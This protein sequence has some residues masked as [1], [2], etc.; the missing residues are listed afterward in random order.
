MATIAFLHKD[1][2]YCIPSQGWP[3][4]HSFT[5]MATITFLHKDGHY[6][7]P[8]QGWPLLHSFS[9]MATI[10]F[11]HKDGHYCIPSQGWP[12]L[13]SFTRM[14]TIAFLHKDGHYCIPSQ[15]WPLL[16]SFSRMATIE[17]VHCN[18]GLVVFAVKLIYLEKKVEVLLLPPFICLSYS[19]LQHW[20]ISAKGQSAL[21]MPKLITRL[22]LLS[23]PV[24]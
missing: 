12:L 14:A 6:C 23:S 19:L 18:F 11:L 13:Y 20:R 22:F 16:H 1:G 15:G 8:S 21:R 17:R 3:L 5:R 9:R 24:R 4:L 2:H 7:I 10:V